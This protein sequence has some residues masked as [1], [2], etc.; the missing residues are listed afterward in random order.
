MSKSTGFFISMVIFAIG[1]ISVIASMVLGGLDEIDMSVI[2]CQTVTVLC[3]VSLLALKLGKAEKCDQKDEEFFIE[4][5]DE[6]D[7]DDEEEKDRGAFYSDD[8]NDEYIVHGKFFSDNKTEES[9]ENIP[10]EEE[11]AAEQPEEIPVSNSF[12]EPPH[13]EIPFEEADELDLE[14]PDFE[15]E[16]EPEELQMGLFKQAEFVDEPDFSV[17]PE[18]EFTVSE[19]IAAEPQFPTD[20]GNI[21]TEPAE[22]IDELKID[23]DP[24]IEQVFE[25]QTE[26]IPE[27][28][29]VEEAPAR[30]RLILRVV[31]VRRVR[32][33]SVPLPKKIKLKK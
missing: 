10:Q 9:A 15:E 11:N 13:Q 22:S 4:Q 27:E 24:L 19:E 2:V 21:D 25:E 18:E 33:Y 29:E 28:P 5:D 32:N 8:T 20:A 1:V 6:F 16:S 23:M 14:V 17:A 12:E 30:K 7:E 31:G 26:T 3:M